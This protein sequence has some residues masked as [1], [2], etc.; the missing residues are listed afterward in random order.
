M[1]GIRPR[2]PTMPPVMYSTAGLANSW[3]TTWPPTSLS[4][5]TRETTIPA[6]IEMISDGICATRPSPIASSV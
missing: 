1:P 3:L 2:P 6:A 5:A 4:L